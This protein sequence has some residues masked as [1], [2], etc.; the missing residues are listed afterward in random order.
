MKGKGQHRRVVASRLMEPLP[1]GQGL[2]LREQVPSSSFCS[3]V[4][5]RE[6]QFCASQAALHKAFTVKDKTSD[7]VGNHRHPFHPEIQ[8]ISS[9]D[10]QNRASAQRPTLV[11]PV[12]L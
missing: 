12:P 7:S 10:V 4:P 3:M 1:L 11:K 8:R 5:G 9:V 6:E 2:G